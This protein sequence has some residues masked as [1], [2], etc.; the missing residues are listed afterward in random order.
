[1]TEPRGRSITAKGPQTEETG[2][3][4]AGEAEKQILP[5]RPPDRGE[6]MRIRKRGDCLKNAFQS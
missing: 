4:E 5:L 2:P 1:M 3:L 6:H